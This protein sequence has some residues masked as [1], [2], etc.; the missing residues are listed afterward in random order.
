[1]FSELAPNLFLTHP[2]GYHSRARDADQRHVDKE[3]HSVPH[4]I[5]SAATAL[6]NPAYPQAGQH[7]NPFG[8]DGGTD[9]Q[10]AISYL[11]SLEELK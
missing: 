11:T 9:E 4:R 5:N 7:E 6:A 10:W 8:A 1:M 2:G 3:L